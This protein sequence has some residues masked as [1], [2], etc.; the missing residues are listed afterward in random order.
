MKVDQPGTILTDQLG[1]GRRFGRHGVAVQQEPAIGRID[2]LGQFNRLGGG[3]QEIRRSWGQ[4]FQRE[5]DA[6]L[7]QGGHGS[8]QDFGRAF[9]GSIATHSWQDIALLRRAENHHISTQVAAESRQFT[10]VPGGIG[11]NSLARAGQMQSFSLRQQPMKADNAYTRLVGLFAQGGPF[12]GR[13]PSH[14]VVDGKRCDLSGGV[15]AFGKEREYLALWPVFEGLVAHRVSHGR[16]LLGA[17]QR[18]SDLW[19]RQDTTGTNTGSRCLE[20]SAP[21]LTREC[22]HCRLLRFLSTRVAADHT[23]ERICHTCSCTEAFPHGARHSPLH[24]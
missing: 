10:Q 22:V 21:C 16:G 6:E 20:E 3:G 14:A 9:H 7:L 17:A 11:S 19:M 1:N 4:R 18:P 13:D 8:E 12:F 24:C 2:H 15:A 23:C 5:Q